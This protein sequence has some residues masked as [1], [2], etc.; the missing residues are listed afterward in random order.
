VLV[1]LL[2]P[3]LLAAESVVLTASKDTTIFSRNTQNSNALGVLFTSTTNQANIRRSLLAFD[4]AAHVPAGSTITSAVLTLTLVEAAADGMDLDHQLHRLLQ[5]WGEGSSSTTG[6]NGAPA[7]AGDATWTARLFPDT[8]WSAP[9]GDFQVSPSATAVVGDTTG[10]IS[11]GSTAQMVSD[12]QHW[13]DSPDESHGW[14]VLGNETVLGTARKFANRE[15]PDSSIRPTLAIEYTAP[16]VA[17]FEVW[18]EFSD[19]RENEVEV[20]LSCNT[21]IPLDQNKRITGGGSSVN[22]VVKHIQGEAVICEV[23]ESEGV[24]GYDPVF[25]GGAGCRWESVTAG[26]QYTCEIVNSARPATFTVT[27]AW[28]YAG[29][30]TE[31]VS[32]K[33]SLS[34]FC[35]NEI[36]GGFYNGTGYQYDKVL[37]GDDESVEV[38]VDTLARPAECRAEE[39]G[40][41]G[42]V[43]MESDCGPRSIPAGGSSSCTITNTVFFEGIPTLNETGLA[44]LALLASGMGA[45]FLRRLI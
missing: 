44:L 27:K 33:P 14:I 11:W 13:L 16:T 34:V 30:V 1:L 22:F 45:A 37:S 43:E 40:A 31:T 26:Q 38:S 6:G 42:G 32:M 4:V 25:N 21:G 8:L 18:K 19:G 29:S 17:R 15:D 9:G 7:T 2:G 12:A 20:S 28:L 36:V 10:A 35:N 5:E 23:L 24:D 41:P 39:S 3:V